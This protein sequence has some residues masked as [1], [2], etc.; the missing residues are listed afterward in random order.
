MY[1]QTPTAE[2]LGLLVVGTTQHEAS[3]ESIHRKL[4]ES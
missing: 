1:D 3:V 4:S 2:Y